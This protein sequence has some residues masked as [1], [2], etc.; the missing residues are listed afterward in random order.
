MIPPY[1]Y[2]NRVF[3]VIIC[4]SDG[5]ACINPDCEHRHEVI[6]VVPKVRHDLIAAGSERQSALIRNLE[7]ERRRLINGPDHPA[8]KR[9]AAGRSETRSYSRASSEE[10]TR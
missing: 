8:V 1:K 10:E 4:S 5:S 3:H 2:R 6:E 7:N 9:W